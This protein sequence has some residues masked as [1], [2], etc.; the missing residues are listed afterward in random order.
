MLAADVLHGAVAAQAGQH[1]LD[2]LLRR[3]AAVLASLAQP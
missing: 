3:P 2:L 1:D